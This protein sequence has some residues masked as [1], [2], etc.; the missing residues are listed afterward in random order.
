MPIFY[1]RMCS[2]LAHISIDD[3]NEGWIIIM[4]N[5]PDNDEPKIIYDYFI[6]QWLE[7]PNISSEVWNCHKKDIGKTILLR[8]GIVNKIKY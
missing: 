5:K 6:E 7:N 3:I 4:S 2:A 8:D 1:Y